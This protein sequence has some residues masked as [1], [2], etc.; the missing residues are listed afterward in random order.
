VRVLLLRPS[1]WY[2]VLFFAGFLAVVNIWT[3]VSLD[4][5][6][7]LLA[8]PRP[9]AGLTVALDPGHGGPD[10]GVVGKQ[11]N[12]EKD[13]VLS[14][15]LVLREYLEGVGI[16]VIMTREA[17][18]DLGEP[19]LSL[20][21]RKTMDLK[22]RSDIINRAS[23]DAFISIHA[24]GFPAPQWY[25]AQTFYSSQ[26]APGSDILAHLI[27]E[28]LIRVTR[29]T[30]R[31][32]SNRINQ[33]LLNEAKVPSVT[34]EVG[35]MSNP[36]EEKM[37]ASPSYQREVAWAIFCGIARF[38]VEAVPPDLKGPSHE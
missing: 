35:F 24:N 1:R 14:I 26:G 12:L 20:S 2:W 19:G 32:P 18:Y 6:D 11:G 30:T 21:K 7:V 16:S 3:W 33:Y 28:E 8:V 13:V 5:K 31:K 17:D 23:P 15:A 29:R 25:G 27:Q 37:L 36:A 9:L 10:P 22:R 34:V 4:T 38:F